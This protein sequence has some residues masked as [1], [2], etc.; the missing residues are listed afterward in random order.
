MISREHI[1]ESLQIREGLEGL[2]A[3]NIATLYR[4]APLNRRTTRPKDIW[5]MYQSSSLVVSAWWED[6]L[7]GIAR[8]LSD[9]IEHSFLCDLAVEP[10]VQR[11]GVGRKLLKEVREATK[12]TD[13]ML[14]DSQ[15]QSQY[16]AK[17]GFSKVQN[18]WMMKA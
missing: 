5:S 15:I 13:L 8:V 1:E 17:A 9:G 6:R 11:L 10:D 4:R 16:Y 2:T 7:V 3:S 14:R 18:A 12:G